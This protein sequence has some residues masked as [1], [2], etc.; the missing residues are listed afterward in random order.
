MA[1]V[2]GLGCYFNK[3]IYSYSIAISPQVTLIC[4]CL[5]PHSSNHCSKW[6][7][8][9]WLWSGSPYQT[10]SSMSARSR[11]VCIISIFP[12]LS[13]GLDTGL[14]FTFRTKCL[15]PATL[16][17]WTLLNWGCG[18]KKISY[19]PR[20][21]WNPFIA[22]HDLELLILLLPHSGYYDSRH[23]SLHLFGAVLGIKPRALCMLGKTSANNCNGWVYLQV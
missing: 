18:G 8:Y 5:Y 4:H 15:P 20:L 1:N 19:N 17:E 2:L 22:E 11:S 10:E 12:V 6:S 3:K 23:G 13:K 9:S 21:P 16:P 14:E 7:L